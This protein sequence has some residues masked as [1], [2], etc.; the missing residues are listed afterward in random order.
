MYELIISTPNDRDVVMTR[1]FEAPRTSVFAALTTPALL[2]TWLQAPGRAMTTCEIDLRE[3]GS[4]RHVWSGAGKKDVGTHGVYRDVAVPE[5]I[6]CT[7]SWLDWDAGE[8]LVTTVLTEQNGV[9]TLTMTSRFPSPAV[10]DSVLKSGLE[11]N[12]VETYNRLADVLA[13]MRAQ[14]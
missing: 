2:R 14:T 5:R 8:T 10:R 11:A 4:Y 7:E 13:S 12:A 9:T 3:G 1:R 6:V